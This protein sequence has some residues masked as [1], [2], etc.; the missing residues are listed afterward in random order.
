MLESKRTAILD[1]DR[2]SRTRSI[3]VESVKL[4]DAVRELEKKSAGV[5]GVRHSCADFQAEDVVRGP[6]DLSQLCARISS[7]L[8]SN[9][10]ANAKEAIVSDILGHAVPVVQVLEVEGCPRELRVVEFGLAAPI[11]MAW[12]FY[13]LRKAARSQLF[14]GFKNMPRNRNMQD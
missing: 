7:R 13:C 1:R 2:T 4:P 10:V 3:A 9:D 6:M 14:V 12:Y 11:Q 8:R 5:F